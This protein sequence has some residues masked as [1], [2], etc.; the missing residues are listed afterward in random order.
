MR[1][2]TGFARSLNRVDGIARPKRRSTM[3]KKIQGVKIAA[4]PALPPEK[5]YEL[6][7]DII[8]TWQWEG[9]RLGRIELHMNGPI[10]RAFAFEKP[11]QLTIPAKAAVKA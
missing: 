6:A 10:I 5:V 9:R 1:K 2:A 7:V 8:R 11:F 4:D 3:H